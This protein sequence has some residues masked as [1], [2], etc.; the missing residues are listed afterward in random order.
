MTTLDDPYPL[1]RFVDAPDPDAV[2]RFDFNTAGEWA[3]Q[4]VWPGHDGWTLGSP[5]REGDPDSYNTDW[6]F[7]RASFNLIVE[8]TK[9]T[10]ARVMSQLSRE[11]LRRD[12]WLLFQLSE[13]SP[14]VWLHTYR[15]TEPGPLDF[16]RVVNRRDDKA[17]RWG[18]PVQIDADAFLYGERVTIDPITV[19]NSP[20]DPDHPMWFDLP[21]I[22]GDAPVP[23]RMRV[24]PVGTTNTYFIHNRAVH[25][26]L[27]HASNEP[28]RIPAESM[29]PADASVLISPL[30]TDETLDQRFLYKT[31]LPTTGLFKL[32]TTAANIPF[33]LYRIMLRTEHNSGS[34]TIYDSA[35]MWVGYDIDAITYRKTFDFRP[36][37]RYGKSIEH[38]LWA[39]MGE[40]QHPFGGALDEGTAPLNLALWAMRSTMGG[41]AGYRW[42]EILLVPI[43]EDEPGTTALIQHGTYF[44]DDDALDHA[45]IYDGASESVH[46]LADGVPISAFPGSVINGALPT[47]IPGRTNR[48]LLNLGGAAEGVMDLMA[49]DLEVETEVTVSYQPQY[50]YL[51][52]VPDMEV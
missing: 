21:E 5:V 34:V 6:G 39:N 49:D 31:A 8:G 16:T 10:A 29:T 33:G 7:R 27:T 13:F 12:N 52:S 47:A 3:D 51:A 19:V 28:V 41:I 46:L 42:D 22:L 50:L 11:L 2:V 38:Y 20:A 37:S 44:G 35:P 26:M 32:A 45:W 18:I 15:S 23:L 40:I 14:P 25:L 4:K 36:T 1:V 43:D 24:E 17:D 9:Q 30:A 48:I